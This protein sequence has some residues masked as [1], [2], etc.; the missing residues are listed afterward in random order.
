M[1]GGYSSDEEDQQMGVYGPM[2]PH[3]QRPGAED[4]EEEKEDEY[5]G[6]SL[7]IPA[8]HADLEEESDSTERDPIDPRLQNSADLD[9]PE[10][11]THS[12]ESLSIGPSLP[13]SANP[14][15]PE[16]ES[17]SEGRYIGPA[18]PTNF[19]PAEPQPEADSY[20]PALPGFSNHQNQSAGGHDSD[21]DFGPMPMNKEWEDQE[22]FARDL[23]FAMAEDKK[24]LEESKAPKR[25]DWMLS[26]PKTL[27]NI[28]LGPRTF[29][30]S[31][32]DTDKS[33]EDSPASKKSSKD[34]KKPETAAERADR[35]YQKSQKK[36]AEEEMKETGPS[37][38]D[39]HQKDRRDPGKQK[40]LAPG[41]RRPFDREKDM[42][43]SGLKPGAQKEAVDRMKELG[44]RF[45]SSKYL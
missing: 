6:P 12:V 38:L 19:N 10:D 9:D 2:P 13:I 40:E 17:D 34:E 4:L 37:L 41:E 36:R 42:A 43:V 11:D 15:E 28:G 18:L 7:P 8:K 31:A 39:L 20:G 45:T 27:G 1:A 33:W 23:R 24:L 21:D 44:S 30:R 26:V 3:L 16:E 14:G 32:V 25:E 29:K 35:E 22:K 5:I